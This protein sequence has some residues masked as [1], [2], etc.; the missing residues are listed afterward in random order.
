MKAKFGEGDMEWFYNIPTGP[1][2]CSVWMGIS[3]GLEE[4]LSYTR[5]KVNKGN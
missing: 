3:R 5:F 4:F 1:V 2:G